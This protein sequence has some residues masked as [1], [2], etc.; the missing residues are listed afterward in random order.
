MYKKL[1][2]MTN[3]EIKGKSRSTDC[4]DNKAFFVIEGSTKVS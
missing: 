2:M 1:F 4:L 3:N